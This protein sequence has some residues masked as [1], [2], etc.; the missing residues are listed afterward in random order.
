MMDYFR[1]RGSTL[2]ARA[3]SQAYRYTVLS[4]TGPCSQM[5][6]A[7]QAAA[8][9]LPSYGIGANST[10]NHRVQTCLTATPSANASTLLSVTR[11]PHASDIAI[12]FAPVRPAAPHS[13]PALNP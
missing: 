9:L 2:L 3:L 12:A 11:S 1:V 4:A 6:S 13:I 8:C 5:E 7:L 10:M